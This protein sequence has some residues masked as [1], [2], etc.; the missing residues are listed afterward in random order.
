[1]RLDEAISAKITSIKSQFPDAEIR[2]RIIYNHIP[3]YGKIKVEFLAGTN[4]IYI[5]IPPSDFAYQQTVNSPYESMFWDG[6]GET[7]MNYKP[8]YR[9]F[10]NVEN[11]SD[12][13]RSEE[14]DE[15]LNDNWGCFAE[16]YYYLHRI[17]DVLAMQFHYPNG[18]C[19]KILT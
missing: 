9:F 13:L 11:D 2:V 6:L 19:T 17:E 3:A 16:P 12:L 4:I 18:S 15:I 14:V 10:P 7:Y 1:M 8:S 5:S